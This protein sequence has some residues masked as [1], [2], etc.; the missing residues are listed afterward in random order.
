MTNKIVSRIS[1][2]GTNPDANAIREVSQFAQSLIFERGIESA[3]MAFV[4][5]KLDE[6]LKTNKGSFLLAVR[7]SASEEDGENHSFAG[8]YESVIGIDSYA[9]LK[10]AILTV[11]ASYYSERAI[12]YRLRYGY[13]HQPK[14]NILIQ[15]MIDGSNASAGI[16]LS[17]LDSEHVFI[18][19]SFGLCNAITDGLINTD[20]FYVQI[21][22]SLISKTK[23]TVKNKKSAF[24]L[25]DNQIK[26]M[27][28]GNEDAITPSL[29]ESQLVE[30][31]NVASKLSAHFGYSIDMEWTLNEEGKLYI[32]QAR[33]ETANI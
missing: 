24:D 25:I 18:A 28:L 22:T 4:K 26:M 6:A 27:E 17:D 13:E 11:Y 14:M 5:A 8:Q 1:D 23:L 31:A 19:S 16:A 33:K 29:S 15:E 12:A 10:S 2:L 21:E 3:E 9:T 30:I 20:E 7:S 32:L